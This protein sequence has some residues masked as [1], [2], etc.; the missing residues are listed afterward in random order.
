MKVFI[1]SS[2][3]VGKTEVVHELINRGYT[4]YNADDR[5]LRLT[6]L[7]VKETPTRY[8]QKR[9]LHGDIKYC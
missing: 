3:G 4:A 6:R 9:I 1:S 5:D 2:S 8:V 7:E